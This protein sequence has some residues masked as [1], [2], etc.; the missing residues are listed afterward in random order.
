MDQENQSNKYIYLYKRTCNLKSLIG[1]ELISKQDY[2]SFIKKR[3]TDAGYVLDNEFKSVLN[4]LF[5]YFWN[6]EEFETLGHGS[7]KKGIFLVGNTGV[8]KTSIMRLFSM[9]PIQFMEIEP[10][11]NVTDFYETWGIEE[12]KTKYQSNCC[13]F[14]DFGSESTNVYHKGNSI[15]V[16]ER[17]ILWRYDTRNFNQT[18][19]TSNLDGSQLE[20]IYGTRIRSRLKEMVNFIELSGTDRRR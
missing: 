7:L 19:F 20:S 15:N 9:N 3:I 16:M 12:L 13:C 17:V 8:G 5:L 14:D 10:V 1:T 6:D 4:T 18:H 11:N 2:F